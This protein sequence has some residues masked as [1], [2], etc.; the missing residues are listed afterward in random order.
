M[1]YLFAPEWFCTHFLLLTA[2]S[3]KLAA[4]SAIITRTIVGNSG[5]VGVAIGLELLALLGLWVGSV[6]WLRSRVRCWT[7]LGAGLLWQFRSMLTQKFK[8]VRV[9]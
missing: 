2:D 5:T 6:C 4:A 1:F 9:E 7:W 8:A 3:T